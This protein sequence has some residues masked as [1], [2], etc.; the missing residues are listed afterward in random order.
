M[1]RLKV[2]GQGRRKNIHVKRL[3]GYGYFILFLCRAIGYRISENKKQLAHIER[4]CFL[5][6][7]NIIEVD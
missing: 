7:S 4:S 2:P 1:P 5:G 6:D 3:M